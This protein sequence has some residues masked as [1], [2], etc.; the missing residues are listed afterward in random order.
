MKKWDNEYHAAMSR[1]K[2]LSN[3]GGNELRELAKNEVKHLKELR[4]ELFCGVL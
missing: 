3:V 2:R 1:I 4:H